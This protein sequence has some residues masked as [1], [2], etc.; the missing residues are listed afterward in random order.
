MALAT[1][2]RV[3]AVLLL[4]LAALFAVWFAGDARYLQALAVFS[5]PPLLLAVGVL[6]LRRTAPFWAGVLAL[7]WFC[8]GVMLA[9]ERAEGRGFA[10]AEVA[11]ALGIVCASSW[12]GLRGRF[13][14]R[15]EGQAR[16]KD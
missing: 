8:H 15:R 13:R 5:L 12:P 6:A 7:G 4:A 9:W 2:Q 1:S 16:A 3:L 11:L 10:L 14:G